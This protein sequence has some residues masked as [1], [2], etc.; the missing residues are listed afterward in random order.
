VRTCDAFCRMRK[1]LLI[2]LI[3]LGAGGLV[4]LAVV[5][6]QRR[7]PVYDGESLSYW[8]E[9]YY[10]SM[11]A[12][13]WFVN[14]S[15]REAIHEAGT[16]AVPF[17]IQWMKMP[18][19]GSSDVNRNEWARHGFEVLGPTAK[20]AVPD[21]V[22]LLGKR[23][24]YP[25][26]ALAAIGRDAVPAIANVLATNRSFRFQFAAYEALSYMGTNAESA[27]P[28]LLA[29]LRRP[30]GGRAALTLAEVCHNRPQ[31]VIPPLVDVLTRAGGYDAA[32][33]ADAL[34]S[35][36]PT[37]TEAVPALL[38]ASTNPVA[39]V[40]THASAALQ[41]IAP[42]TKDALRPLIRNLYTG[43]V[44]ERQQALW[45]LKQLGTNGAGAL[46]ALVERGLR[47]PAPEVRKIAIG[48][49]G[50]IGLVNDA[51]VAGLSENVTNGNSF[52]ACQAVET[53]AGFAGRSKP[54]F[55]A[56]LQA[57][58]RSPLSEVRGQ[59]EMYLES[60]AEQDPTFLVACMEHSDPLLRRCA[61][62]IQAHA[63][64]IIPEAIPPLM[65]ALQDEDPQVRV[66]ATNS[67]I[68][69]DSDAA[70]RAGVKLPP[71]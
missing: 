60:A 42:E 43:T 53:V 66:A 54:A 37:A 3:P 63:N 41:R 71:R 33:I 5:L 44:S 35:F 31:E 13:Q 21:L 34:G 20:A 48:C 50:S 17:L 36:G 51:V 39:D 28:C 32:A 65:R 15:A 12:G 11:V 46:P 49:V 68:M 1:A 70:R 38:A 69:V 24:N 19:R 67:L 18:G 64:K 59:A 8:M 22:S 9:H 2:S 45:T 25:S 57:K 52:V 6:L 14:P 55:V 56:L 29:C 47:D 26:L 62:R 4:L 7:E 30:Y 61:V 10:R 40:R 58:E 23:G 16:N 27:L